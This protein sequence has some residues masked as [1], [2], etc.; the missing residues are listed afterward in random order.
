MDWIPAYAGMTCH[1]LFTM[2][3]K[4]YV[5]ILTN[6]RNG[7]LYIGM[8]NDVIRRVYEHKQKRIKGF[9]KK[10]G[11]SKLVHYEEYSFVNDA[12][13]R[14]KQLKTWK[15]NWKIQLIEKNNPKW[16]DLSLQFTGLE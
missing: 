7:T 3:E 9:T 10:Y 12:I 16:L 1:R 8:T 2:N 15:R 5:Y 14:E 6:K 11:L 13:V 4:Y